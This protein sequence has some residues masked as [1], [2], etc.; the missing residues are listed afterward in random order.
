MPAIDCFELGLVEPGRSCTRP[1]YLSVLIKS[2]IEQPCCL[3][4]P[5]RVLQVFLLFEFRKLAI[6]KKILLETRHFTIGNNKLRD[7][8]VWTKVPMLT[9]WGDIHLLL[10]LHSDLDVTA[11]G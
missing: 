3:L 1:E 11:V 9:V 7:L 10:L 6:M 8:D 4:S 5:I 2:V